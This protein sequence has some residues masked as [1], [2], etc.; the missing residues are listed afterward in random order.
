VQRA[1][2]ETDAD[3]Q[4]RQMLALYISSNVLLE[5]NR[6]WSWVELGGKL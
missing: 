6:V 3:P 5:Q 4:F 2:N 1:V